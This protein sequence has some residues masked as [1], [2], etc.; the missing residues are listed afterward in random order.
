[1][2]TRL[3]TLEPVTPLVEDNVADNEQTQFIAMK[4]PPKRGCPVGAPY[5]FSGT[6]TITT[7]S[8]LFPGSPGAPSGPGFPGAPFCPVCPG[9][10]CGPGGPGGP[11]VGVG[12][13]TGVGTVTTAGGGAG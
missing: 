6:G 7:V 8:L 1:M 13:G 5:F 11:G 12:T 2:A 4:T 9:S 10:P 3:S